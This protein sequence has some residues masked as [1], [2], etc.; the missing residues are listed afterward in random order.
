MLRT[1]APALDC[2]RGPPSAEAFRRGAA[3]VG[4]DDCLAPGAASRALPAAPRCLTGLL[5]ETEVRGAALGA[6]LLSGAKA[7]DGEQGLET[8]ATHQREAMSLQR[9]FL[10][11][12]T[13]RFDSQVDA[14]RQ[15]LSCTARRSSRNFRPQLRQDNNLVSAGGTSNKW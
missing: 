9:C 6:P 11:S 13:C 4:V 10:L 5:V 14:L 2:A 12:K 8:S 3:T 7:F 15:M 1:G